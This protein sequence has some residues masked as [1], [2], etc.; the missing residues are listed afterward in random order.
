[1]LERAHNLPGEL[2]N[3]IG[4]TAEIAELERLFTTTRLLT[5]TGVAGIGKTRLALRL[6]ADLAPQF[7]DGVW[8]VELA[9]VRDPA[10]VPRTVAAVV[11]V[12]GVPAKSLLTTLAAALASRRLLLVLDNCEHLIGS[13]ARLADT[14]LRACPQL[15]ILATSR[16]PLHIPGELAWHV[17][18]LALPDSTHMTSTE[19]LA[20]LAQAEALSMFLDRAQSHRPDFTLTSRN[21]PA[22]AAICRRLEGLPLAIELAAAQITTVAPEQIASLLDD[23]LHLLAGGNRALP[24]QETLRATLDWSHA[25]LSDSERLLFRRLSA[26]AGSFDLAAVEAMC[27]DD[28]ERT[29]VLPV[30]RALVEKSL[31]EGWTPAENARYRL[32]EPV[33]HYA[34]AQLAASGETNAIQRRHAR[35]FLALAEEANLHVKSAQRGPWLDRLAL[36]QDN[37]RAALAWSKRATEP[38]DIE[39]GLRL[40]GVLLWHWN[41][42]G[43]SSEGLDWIETLLARAPAA[44]PRTRAQALYSAGEFS[45]LLG[46]NTAARTRLEESLTLWRALGDKEGIA[47][48]LQVLAGITDDPA[49]ATALCE[50]SVAL[51]QELGNQ[52]GVAFATHSMSLLPHIQRD[53]ATARRWLEMAQARYRALGDDW[54]VAHTLNGLGDLA[55]AAGEPAHAAALYEESLALAQKLGASGIIPGLL[56][57]L[58]Y[59]ALRRHD[60]QRALRYFRE[61]LT[62]FRRQGDQRGIAECLAGLAGVLGALKQPAQAARLFGTAEYLMQTSGVELSPS[63]HADYAQNVALVREQLDTAAFAAA[64]AEGRQLSSEQAI[65]MLPAAGADSDA[66]AQPPASPQLA[67]LTPRERE[68]A[69]LLGRGLTNRQIAAALVITEGTARLHV[70]H[71]LHKLGFTSRAQVAAWAVSCGLI[72]ESPAP[73]IG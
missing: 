16:E 19:S 71:L 30:L 6:A 45:W 62:L 58:G 60:M 14:L 25:L 4:R 2:T 23:T 56:H 35:Y 66:P 51:F 18:P 46:N 42:R 47:Y 1:M 64:W 24:R 7:P 41:F 48:T 54:F 44:T 32:L 39:I 59:L 17:P 33:R 37:L 40:A 31:V 22:I 26:F 65:A 20:Q 63:N 57:N 29:E 15:R 3:F 5:L 61:S 28:I 27:Q 11:G 73:I 67:Y 53:L 9:A 43:E 55:R 50:E 34:S 52:W 13:C 68:V 70:K 8:L 49:R 12:R 10:L 38:D 21:A 72:A 69:A 36:E